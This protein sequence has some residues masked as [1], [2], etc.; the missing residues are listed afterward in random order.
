[1]SLWF[2]AAIQS[3]VAAYFS[4]IPQLNPSQVSSAMVL[5]DVRKPEEYAVSHIQGA[6]NL[7][8]AEDV[9]RLIDRHPGQPIVFYC[10]VGVR[11]SLVAQDVQHQLSTISKNSGIVPNKVYNLR[12]GIFRWAI[13]HMPVVNQQGTTPFVHGFGWPWKYLLPADK[14]AP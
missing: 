12:G 5:V 13:E 6:V 4:A 10:S 3:L 1:M 8:R 7:P 11:S 2:L 9:M 14:R